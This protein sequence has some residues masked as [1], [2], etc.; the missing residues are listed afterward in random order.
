MFVVVWNPFNDQWQKR[1]LP[2]KFPI[3]CTSTSPTRKDIVAIGYVKS[4]SRI[5]QG[6]TNLARES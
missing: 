2:D 6:A 3:S 4:K 5:I 1:A